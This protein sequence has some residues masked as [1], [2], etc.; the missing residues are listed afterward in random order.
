MDYD[1]SLYLKKIAERVEYYHSIRRRTFEYIRT[2]NIKDQ[3]L[4]VQLL[5]MAAVWASNKRNEE[6]TEEDLAIFFG[7]KT[8]ND[9]ERKNIVA[10]DMTYKDL[11]L[12]QLLDITVES[13][14]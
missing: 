8:T 4:I 12:A 14:K 7:L 1:N 6:I 10:I 11:T 5:I 9:E 2:K 13:F 3:P